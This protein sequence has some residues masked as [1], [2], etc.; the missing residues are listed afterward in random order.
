MKISKKVETALGKQVVQE[1][2]A[3]Y[4]YYSA[5]GYFDSLNLKG[6]AK[7]MRHHAE[8]ELQHGKKIYDYVHQRG[9]RVK[10]TAIKE[11][12]HEW[13]S[14]VAAVKDAYNHEL[15]VTGMI[16]DLIDLARKED[17][18]AT[19]ISLQWFITGQLCLF[20]TASWT[21]ENSRKILEKYNHL[22]TLLSTFL[23]NG[24]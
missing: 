22:Y 6:L 16:N 23:M 10:L 8:E 5:S 14:P 11:P 12:K 4:L 13:A 7:W 15:M 17:D 2:Y 21:N 20:L 18:K 9:G 3:A 19:E 24:R 1:F